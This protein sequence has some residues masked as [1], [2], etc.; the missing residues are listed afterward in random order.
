[1]LDVDED[2]DSDCDYD[3]DYDSNYSCDYDIV[4]SSILLVDTGIEESKS[5][6]PTSHAKPSTMCKGTEVSCLDTWDQ[7]ECVV[8]LKSLENNSNFAKILACSL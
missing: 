3:H 8:T 2:Y 7:H 4:S 1:M 5:S 6:S